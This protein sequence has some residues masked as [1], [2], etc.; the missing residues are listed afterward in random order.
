MPPGRRRDVEAAAGAANVLE[1]ALDDHGGIRLHAPQQRPLAR[2][3][4]EAEDRV[5][6]QGQRRRP[7]AGGESDASR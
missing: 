4:A 7:A 2:D 3:Q 1:R 5:N 6:G